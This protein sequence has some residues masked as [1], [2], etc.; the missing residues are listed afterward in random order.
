MVNDANGDDGF[1]FANGS[2]LEQRG[3]HSNLQNCAGSPFDK[4][5]I[6]LTCKLLS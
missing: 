1:F 3:T 6:L 2:V 5:N 4:I